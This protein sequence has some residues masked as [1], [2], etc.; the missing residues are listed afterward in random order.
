MEQPQ[1]QST[2][3]DRKSYN[4]MERGG[5]DAKLSNESRGEW[6]GNT[7]E[8]LKM[9]MVQTAAEKKLEWPARD[10]KLREDPKRRD[11]KHKSH[12][13]DKDR[14]HKKEKKRKREEK[15][16]KGG[17]RDKRRKH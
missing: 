4:E 3:G 5:G 14:K 9:L 15:R 17:E 16:D 6:K 10:E 11:R 7:T 1:R 13:K 8:R 12:K 2:H